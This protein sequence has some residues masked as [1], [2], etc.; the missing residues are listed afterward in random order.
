MALAAVADNLRDMRLLVFPA[1]DLEP[2][3]VTALVASVGTAAIWRLR[4]ETQRL[5]LIDRELSVARQIQSSILP[6]AMP[7]IPGLTA[8]ARYRPMMA[9][10]GDF[11]DFLGMDSARIGILV[12]DVSGHGVPAALIA[13]M[14][15]VALAAQSDRA[16]RPA[17]VLA[18]LNQSLWGHLAGQYIT[19]AYA[20]IDTHSSSI[21]YSAAGHPPM[22]RL[23]RRS[24]EARAVEENGLPLGML[25]ATVYKEVELS[26]QGGDRLLLYTDG[27]IEAANADGDCFGLDRL[28]ATLARGSALQL[29]A[30]ADHIVRTIDAWSGQP[31]EDD[32]TI[33]LVDWANRPTQD[34]VR[35]R[36]S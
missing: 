10:S 3:G 25:K 1:P 22:L 17:A 32:S 21:R 34:V 28:K 29:E 8:F 15:K 6:Q 7:R 36:S 2:F 26:L 11:Y 33:V 23:A 4:G 9:V 5:A 19:A 24:R 18:G 14:V 27:L 31:Q 35:R 30:A 16:D 12:A 20:F 13:S